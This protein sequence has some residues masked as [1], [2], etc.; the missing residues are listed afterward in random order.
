M[1]HPEIEAKMRE[2]IDVIFPNGSDDYTYETVSREMPYVKAVFYET[3]RLF[4]P[5]AISGVYALGPDVL[6]DGTRIVAGDA[7]NF[8]MHCMA[9]DTDIWGPNAAEFCPDRWLQ[10]DNLSRSPFGKFKP[11]NAFKFNSFNGGPRICLGQQFATM[12]AMVTTIY[13]LQNFQFELKPDH[14]TPVPLLALTTP[15]QG[16]LFVRV[17]KRR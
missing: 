5:V 17:F 6:P 10:Y 13:V 7:I 14:P 1:K 11:E 16:G 9:R 15:I 12:E 4:P 8:S 3:L 2:E